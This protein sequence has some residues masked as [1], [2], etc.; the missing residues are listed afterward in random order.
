FVSLEDADNLVNV[1]RSHLL[2]KDSEIIGEVIN[3]YKGKVILRTSIGTKRIL[4][5]HTIEQLPRI[6]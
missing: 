2:G 4:D 1:M 6:C 3:E 5:L